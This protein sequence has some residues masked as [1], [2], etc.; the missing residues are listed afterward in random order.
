VSSVGFRRADYAPERRVAADLRPL[1]AVAGFGRHHVLHETS[2]FEL[3]GSETVEV[4]FILSEQEAR[5]LLSLLLAFTLAASEQRLT[6]PPKWVARRRAAARLRVEAR[7]RYLCIA[8]SH[9]D[10]RRASSEH[11]L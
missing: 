7:S 6:R 3:P 8:A 9:R 2:L 1:W 11:R 5:E 4:E 10:A